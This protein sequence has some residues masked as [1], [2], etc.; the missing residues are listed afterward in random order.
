MSNPETYSPD[1]RAFITLAAV[2][3]LGVFFGFELPD[4]TYGAWTNG[5]LGWGDVLYPLF[6]YALFRLGTEAVADAILNRPAL[7]DYSEFKPGSVLR[8]TPPVGSAASNLE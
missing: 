8:G 1:E 5:E 4:R 7:G 3:Y 6:T 2:I